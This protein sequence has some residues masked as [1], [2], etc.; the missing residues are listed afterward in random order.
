[1]PIQD[2]V[3]KI[4][5]AKSGGV[6]AFPGCNQE[7]IG[8]TSNDIIGQI[9]HI[10]AQKE[11]GPRGIIDYPKEKIDNEDNLILLCPNHH[12]IIDTDT[13]TYTVEAIKYMK[14]SHES[15]IK[16][17]LKAKIIWK[18]KISQLYYMNIPRL[19][20]LAGLS[21][22]DIGEDF[23]LLEQFHCLHAIGFNLNYVMIRISNLINQIAVKTI[24]IKENFSELQVGKCVEFNGNFRTK[25]V[26]YLDAVNRNE[27]KIVG[28]LENDPYLYTKIYN[29]KFILTIDPRWMATTTSFA[30]FKNGW[31]DIAGLAV[32]KRLTCNEIIAT[33][34][35]IG[36]PKSSFD[37][38]LNTTER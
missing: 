36:I 35:V 9:C 7:L 26:P 23:R 11:E 17:L 20:I 24:R 29:T 37:N 19:M 33:P 31:V 12:R 10:V 21:G 4:I 30:Q 6:C 27:F 14:L 1:M 34:Y 2:S 8:N 22:L 3:L 25:N 13:N 38:F 28:S 15:H 32:I 5:W 18:V 16:E